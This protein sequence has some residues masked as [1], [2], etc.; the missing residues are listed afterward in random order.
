[1]TALSDHSAEPTYQETMLQFGINQQ[2]TFRW[3]VP[4]EE[5]IMGTAVAAEGFAFKFQAV[6]GGTPNSMATI[7]HQE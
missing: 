5:G 4:P 6:S 2:A 3:V 7:F 1:M